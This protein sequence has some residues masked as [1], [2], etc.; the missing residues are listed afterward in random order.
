MK[1]IALV[2][3][4]LVFMFGFSQ[5]LKP[6]LLQIEKAVTDKNSPYFYEKLVYRF[7]WNPTMMDTTELHHLY[8]GKSFSTYDVPPFSD[9]ENE[10]YSLFSNGEYPKAIE[11]GEIM[12]RREP[13]SLKVL[14]ILVQAYEAADKN[15]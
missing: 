7:A 13:A 12:V 5:Q 6:N 1:K 11:K 4:L 3:A 14:A 8:Y 2:L 10:L 9:D 15:N